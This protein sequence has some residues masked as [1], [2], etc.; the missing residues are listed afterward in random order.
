M[1]STYM[2]DRPLYWACS[3]G[4]VVRAQELLSLFANINYHYND[5]GQVSDAHMHPLVGA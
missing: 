5:D 1:H 3:H 2:Q 4:D